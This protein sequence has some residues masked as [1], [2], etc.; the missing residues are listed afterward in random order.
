MK[1]QFF[2]ENKT[3]YNINIARQ[4]RA[5]SNDLIRAPLSNLNTFDENSMFNGLL[6]DDSNIKIY[7]SDVYKCLQ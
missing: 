7:V 1:K 4:V 3:L 2:E 6:L 5:K